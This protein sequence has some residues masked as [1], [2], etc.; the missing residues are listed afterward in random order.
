VRWA[1]IFLALVPA[2]VNAQEVARLFGRPVSAA[3]VKMA[4]QASAATG[5]RNLRELVA[6][7]ALA[8]FVAA[9]RLQATAQEIAAYSAWSEEFRKQDEVRRAPKLVEIEAELKEPKTE[10]HRR[11][12]LTQHRDVLLNARKHDAERPAVGTGTS[13]PQAMWIELYKVKKAL[14]EKYGGRVGITKWGPDPVGAMETLLRE[15]EKRGELVILDKALAEEFWGAL[16]KEPRFLAKP[17][18]I[19]FTYYWLKPPK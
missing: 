14:Y 18:Q 16:A 4:G 11:E 13:A 6:K 2:L 7:D 9:N 15:H 17:E 1:W 8:R 12:Q 3:E 5:A 19:D 10:A